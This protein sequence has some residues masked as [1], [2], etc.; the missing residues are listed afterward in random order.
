MSA[1]VLSVIASVVALVVR[2]LKVNEMEE[3]A[4]ATRRVSPQSRARFSGED[5]GEAA[6][7]AYRSVAQ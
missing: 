2:A 5:K 4:D 7:Y 1:Q 3:R 6:L